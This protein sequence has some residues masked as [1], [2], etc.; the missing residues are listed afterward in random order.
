MYLDGTVRGGPVMKRE[1]RRKGRLATSPWAGG[2]TTE[3][4]IHPAWAVCAD[5]NFELRVSSATVETETST[6]SDFS[7]FVRHITP[8]SGTL[9]LVHEGQREAFLGVRE[10]DAFDGGWTTRSFGRCTDFNLIHSPGWRGAISFIQGAGTIPCAADGFT[11]FYA[12]SGGVLI[13]IA[14]Q[15]ASE[16]VLA[17]GDLLIVETGVG[18]N[19]EA[20]L[21]DDKGKQASVVIASATRAC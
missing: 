3:L 12:L 11:V 15:E 14:S 4:F 10:V 20:R 13:G 5:R 2:V 7:G 19:C 8:L 9:K 1:V 21:R 16:T 6:F 17:S 18:E